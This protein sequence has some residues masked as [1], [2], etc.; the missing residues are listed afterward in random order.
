MLG[1]SLAIGV[2]KARQQCAIVV[3][4]WFVPGVSQEAG[5]E[6][7]WGVRVKPQ[8]E[9]EGLCQPMVYLT[10][11]PP[12]IFP[13]HISLT[14]TWIKMLLKCKEGQTLSTEVPDPGLAVCTPMLVHSLP[15]PCVSS[16]CVTGRSLL[17]SR[18]ALVPQ[19]LRLFSETLARWGEKGNS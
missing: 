4:H 18:D 14:T 1:W 16:S 19:P 12:F 5:E 6:G 9:E 15:S 7:H 8:L 17:T 10:W 13:F 11:L 2:W 3:C